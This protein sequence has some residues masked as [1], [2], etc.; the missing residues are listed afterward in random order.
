MLAQV[1][2]GARVDAF[3]FLEPER[4]QELDVGSCIGVMRQLLVV[5]ITVMVITEAQR[6]VPFQAG[7][8]PLL[9]P[10][11]LGA[12][13]NEELHFHLFELAHAEDELACH[14]FIT[15]RLAYLGDCAV[16]GRR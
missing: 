5:V 4:H 2:V 1:E 14:D 10:F 7:F 8:L 11:Q 16:S 13:L 6:L 15:E 12:R 9:K 3:H